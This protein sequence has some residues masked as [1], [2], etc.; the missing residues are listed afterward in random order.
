M[1][2]KL[3]IDLSKTNYESKWVRLDIFCNKYEIQLDSARVYS[4]KGEIFTKLENGRIFID[5]GFLLFAKNF[6]QEL[7]LKNH[8]I[9]YGL[10]YYL[11]ISEGEISR[12]LAKMTGRTKHTWQNVLYASLFKSLNYGIFDVR[13]PHYLFE[14]FVYGTKLIHEVVK[15][16]GGLEKVLVHIQEQGL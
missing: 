12:Y 4:S 13:M 7:W 6:R 8:D 16:R 9:Y 11:G 5:E 3:E 1:Q 14:F 2:G 10:T 15:Q